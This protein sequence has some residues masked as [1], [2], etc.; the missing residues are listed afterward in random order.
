MLKAEM[1]PEALYQFPGSSQ[2]EVAEWAGTPIGKSNTITRTK[3][4]TPSHDK[5]IDEKPGRKEGL[6]DAVVRN[7]GARKSGDF[8]VHDVVVHGIRVRANT[9]S[10]HLA[11]FW[12]DNWYSVAEWKSATGVEPAGSPQVWVYAFCG[13]EEQAEAAYYSR[14]GNTVIFFNTAYYGQLKSWV[15][16]AVG[17]VLAQE[18]GIHSI[19]G[20]VVEKDKKG[21]LYIAPTGTGKSTSSYGLMSFKNA[22]FHSDDWVYVRY[23]YTAKSGKKF[24]PLSIIAGKDEQARGYQCFEWLET[25]SNADA[26]VKGLT[27]EKSQTMEVPVK[28]IDF[29]K[30]LEAYA[31]LSEKVFYL[32][33][34]L[35]ESFPQ[36][37]YSILQSH[38]ENVPD[39][40]PEFLKEHENTLENNLKTI[41][42]TQVPF[43][44]SYFEKWTDPQIKETLG[45]LFAFDNARAMLDITKVFEPHQV[46]VNPLEPVLLTTVMLLKRNFK[47]DSVLETLPQEKFMERLLIGETPMGTREIAYNGYRLVNDKNESAFVKAIEGQSQSGNKPLYKIFSERTDRPSSLTEEFELF[48]AMYKACTCYDLNTILQKDKQIPDKRTAVET[49]MRIIARAMDASAQANLHYDITN[50]R[51]FLNK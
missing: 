46:F 7:L 39:I 40:T 11:Q 20:A 21:V 10:A 34:N 23:A 22:R 17:R 14:S 44:R 49:T 26:T 45:R 15:L 24:S 28:E 18:Y 3:S 5:V 41:R 16:G 13:V 48:R 30:P 47:E 29:T 37:A 43:I 19:H 38:L 32:R 36:A 1:K 12:K 35:V 42:T 51:Q 50:Y 27:L 9:N 25:H 33:C 2:S 6:L 4:R 31:F 8:Y